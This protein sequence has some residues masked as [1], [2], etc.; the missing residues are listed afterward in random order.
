RDLPELGGKVYRITLTIYQ[1]CLTGEKEA[2]AQ[3][4]PAY[5]GIFPFGTGSGLIDTNIAFQEATKVPANFQND[6]VLSI[7]PT[8]LNKVTFSEEYFLENSSAGYRIVYQRCC[9]NASVMN[10]GNPSAIG[11]TFSAVIPPNINNNSAVFR[12]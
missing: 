9:R 1:D 6:C 5:I 10:V 12:N 7:P 2:I 3:D 4:R 8:C 11:A